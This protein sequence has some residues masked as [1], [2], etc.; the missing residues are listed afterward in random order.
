MWDCYMN[1]YDGYYWEDLPASA[2]SNYEILG[3]DQPSW[4]E[5]SYV[6]TAD[7]YWD[8]LSSTQ[9]EAAFG[10]CFFQKSWDWISLVQW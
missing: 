7:M 1:H 9:K 6:D 8:D 4:D 2:A 3:Y 10:L 5:G